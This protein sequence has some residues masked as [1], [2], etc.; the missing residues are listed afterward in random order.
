MNAFQTLK[1]A[2]L[3]TIW[4]LPRILSIICA[5]YF[6]VFSFSVFG[7]GIGTLKPFLLFVVHN[8][9]TAV[10]IFFTIISWKRSWFGGVSFILLGI[11]FFFW[12]P[13]KS[14]S[15][16]SVLPLLLIGLLFSIN[17]VLRK[18]INKARK[19]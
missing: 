8:I 17:W 5:L 10:V 3:L 11:I 12:Q 2:M 13:Y 18:E 19:V 6:G 14:T 1:S 7:Q 16:I 9:P 15:I 4:W